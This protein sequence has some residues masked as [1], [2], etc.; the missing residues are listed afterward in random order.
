ML[1]SN[2][3]QPNDG[4]I[5]ENSIPQNGSAAQPNPVKADSPTEL[6]MWLAGRGLSAATAQHFQLEP[7]RLKAGPGV[8]YPV[9]PTASQKRWKNRTSLKPKYKWLRSK[10]EEVRFYDPDG[11]LEERVRK[12]GGVLY[13]AS[14]DADVWALWEAGIHNATCLLQGEGDPIP[15]WF[16]SG[17]QRL[18]VIEVQTAPDRDD[19]GL[20]FGR[21]VAACL[22]GTD[23]RL[24]QRELPFEMDS[25][26]DIGQLLL[27]IGAEKLAEK[28]QSLP[29][30]QLPPVPAGTA[31]TSQRATAEV[32][33][34][35]YERWC[36]EVEAVARRMW[37]ISDP[38]GKDFSKPLCCPF[39][40]DNSP[41][42]G[43]N[44][45]THSLHCFACR[46]HGT[47][48][49]AEKLG[50]QSWE[51][52]K[53]EQ[54]KKRPKRKSRKGKSSSSSEAFSLD[55]AESEAIDTADLTRE[56]ADVITRDYHF[57]K[58][59]ADNLYYFSGEGYKPG[60]E[61]FIRK[62]VKRL[63][64][65]WGETEHWSTYRHTQVVEFIRVDAPTLWERPRLDIIS[66][67]NGLLNVETGELLPH[68]PDYLSAIQLPV[69]YDPT[70]TPHYWD[71]FC[72]ATLPA[73]AYEA[74]VHWQ[75][76]AWLMT[77]DTHYQKALLLLGDG[78]NGK[79]RF[80]AGLKAFLGGQNVTAMSL[81][82]LESDRFA[83]AR[84][85]GKLANIC[86]D[87]SSQ[88]LEQS[89]MFK[90]LTGDD[91]PVTGEN[92]FQDSFEFCPFARLVFSANQPPLSKDNSEGFYRRWIVLPYTRTFTGSAQVSSQDIDARLSN[93][94]ELSGV[95]NKALEYLPQMR[96]H[97]ITETLSMK[98]TH[99]DFRE[100]TDPLGVWLAEATFAEANAM[101]PQ[102]ALRDAYN[103][104][105]IRQGWP[106]L[107]PQAFGRA[108]KRL[109][110]NVQSTQRTHEG[111][112]K[113]WV[114]LGIALK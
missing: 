55:A 18:G 8:R 92:K 19:K 70:A 64:C 87:L 38:N 73:D 41:S 40:D 45:R 56:L 1:S 43:W 65:H 15:D 99:D 95:L 84:L 78:G 10:P 29:E 58:D 101:I 25:K 24:I 42:A 4:G 108:L 60:G 113:T 57:A 53:A 96:Q 111:K 90:Q 26:G 76:V 98:Q 72:K 81:Q 91:G 31:A 35:D 93:S 5:Y 105:A 62:E 71:E 85:V 89:A 13:L 9:H 94:A 75:V 12:A 102:D 11:K 77:A 68:S 88:H 30:L 6:D 104:T 36:T 83:V 28:L 61:K 112:P 59:A 69:S 49:V 27:E 74:G 7:W 63:L 67:K 86:A 46:D 14:G 21:N 23:I 103:A 106:H 50:V 114:Y 79:S 2:T 20:I 33:N 109:R 3:V 97:G 52:Y 100:T 34:D 107:T 44:Y 80:L 48:E 51:D 39:H 17:L 66:L 82:K 54:S 32:T 37:G 47:K 16:E 22:E 110:P